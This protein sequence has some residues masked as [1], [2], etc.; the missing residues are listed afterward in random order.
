MG[1][2]GLTYANVF[3][4]YLIRLGGGG[5][6]WENLESLRR[7]GVRRE[8]RWKVARHGGGWYDGSTGGKD[9]VLLRRGGVYDG[10]SS[11]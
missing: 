5:R 3:G 6:W 11:D 2:S 4:K 1:L 10:E 8:L 9:R 7:L